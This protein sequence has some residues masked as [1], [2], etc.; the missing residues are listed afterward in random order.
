MQHL[1][2]APQTWGETPHIGYWLTCLH[3]GRT[4]VSTGVS[5]GQYLL[6]SDKASNIS[7]TFILKKREMFSSIDLDILQFRHV[8]MTNLETTTTTIK[9][10]TTIATEETKPTPSEPPPNNYQQQQTT[11]LNHYNHWQSKQWFPIFFRSFKQLI[12]NKWN[13]LF[14][15]VVVTVIQRLRSFAFY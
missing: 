12:F 7:L 1:S 9:N 10:K 13:K 3:I 6:L 2:R 11:V 14:F 8:R 15:V 4:R 5:A